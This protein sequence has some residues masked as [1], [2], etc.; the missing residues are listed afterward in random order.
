MKSQ[1]IVSLNPSKNYE[2]IGEVYSSTHHEIDAKVTDARKAQTSWSHLTVIE[3]VAFLER[4]YQEF[5]ARKNDLRSIISQEMGMPI[6][7]CDQIEI[8]PGLRYMRGY[9]DFADQWLTPEIVYE[10]MDEIHY[11][12]FEPKGVVGI[13]VP[14]NYPFTIFIWSVI[15]N[16]LV[17]NTVVLKHS[18]ECPLTQKLLEQI[19][20]SAGLPD[21]VF[22]AVYG[23]GS[24][25]GQYLMNSSIDLIYFTG[26]TGVGKSL[27][28]IAAQKFIPAVLELGGSAAGIVFQDADVPMT[29]ESI[30][31]YRFANSGQSCDALKRLLVHKDIFEQVVQGLKELI[32][33]KKVGPA[34]DPSTDM[35]PLVAE[36]Q[37]VA[38]ENQVSDALKKGA[39]VIIGAKR[40]QGLQGA[41]F[42]P[43]I[44]T[45]ITFD[46]KVWKEEVFGPVL[47]I[48]PFSSEKEAIALGNDSMY[49]LGGN[50][51]TQDKERALRVS[52]LLQTGNI[53][54]NAANYVIP[55]DPFGGYKH[56]G[57]GREHGKHGLREL[58]SVKLIA[59]KK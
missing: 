50:V 39:K 57:I 34:Q 25:V 6:S 55:Q 36:R 16:L 31:F 30:Y 3:R 56:S 47:P 37:V 54:V 23:D 21:G 19:M 41:Y 42:Q 52:R 4:L 12:Y 15:Q 51:Y 18:E 35:G 7:V 59:L 11:L 22:N 43:T 8:D 45:N 53:S 40:P 20:Q 24:D 14:W 10:T 48:V 29:I 58:C 33:T 49:G 38:L 9:L 26:S 46:M 44:L 17:G 5:I 32:I 1:K 27:Y 13:I 2:V 28:K